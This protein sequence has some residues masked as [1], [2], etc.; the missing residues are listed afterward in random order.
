MTIL[1]AIEDLQTVT[2]RVYDQC[3]EC[4]QAALFHHSQ[5]SK[6]D[7]MNNRTFP[8]NLLK[9][10]VSSATSLSGFSLVGSEML[11]ASQSR[12]HEDI[13]GSGVLVPR[14]DTGSDSGK[15]ACGD[16]GESK[17]GWDWRTRIAR[18][19]QGEDILRDLRLRLAKGLSLGAYR[20][21]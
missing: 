9:K 6:D 21:S 3:E 4:L 12:S 7:N 17:R 15:E 14:P 18:G 19:A 20:A 10:S 2:P 13:G 5:P 8:R 11:E 1:A 16:D